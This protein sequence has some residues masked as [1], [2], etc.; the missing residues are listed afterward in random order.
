MTAKR[1]SPFKNEADTLQIGNLFVKNCLERISLSGSLDITLDREGL[2]K[3]RV[4]MEVL[5]LVMHEMTHTD[6][7]DTIAAAPATAVNPDRG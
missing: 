3:A 2:D 5:S 1:F 6:L 4:L 7:P